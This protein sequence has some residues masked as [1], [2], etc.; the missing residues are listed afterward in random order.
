[1]HFSDIR[2]CSGQAE[3]SHSG[4]LLAISKGIKITVLESATMGQLHSF[5]IVDQA[6]K[7]EWSL[8]DS[9]LL[10]VQSKRGLLQ[11]FSLKDAR[12]ECKIVLGPCGLSSAWLAPDSRHIITVCGQQLRLNFWSLL[13]KE[14]LSLTSP[15]FSSKGV[16]FSRCK[17][18][19][20]V[21]RRVDGRDSVVV[22]DNWFN[23]VS[24]FQLQ[25]VDTEDIYWT[26]DNFYIVAYG[27]TQWS[28]YT[29]SGEIEFQMNNT[30]IYISEGVQSTNGC[31]SAIA[32]CDNSIKI[33]HHITWATLFTFS[34]PTEVNEKE[35]VVYN[36]VETLEK[37]A[38]SYSYEMIEG[39]L[40]LGIVQGERKVS[41]LKWSYNE[42]MVACKFGK[43]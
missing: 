10:C 25:G 21:L 22:F 27:A 12:W 18:F 3:F 19:I 30:G 7:L 29:P 9:L 17:Q 37:N 31:Y 36:E 32:T 28:A 5:S 34:M 20:A 16:A 23:V 38:L 15:K 33:L 1:M 41:I 42:R 11:V 14:V 40:K 2:P 39:R 6:T 26:N 4:S 24:S 35:G 43:K 13:E 8:D